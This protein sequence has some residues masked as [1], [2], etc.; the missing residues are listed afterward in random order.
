MKS[1]MERELKFEGD[2][3]VSID[4]LGGDAI[5]PRTFTSTY[6]DTADTLLLRLGLQLRRRL[7]HGKN[8]WQ[9]KLPREDGR[10]ELEAEGGPAGP[11]PELAGVLRASLDGRELR[12]VA[13]LRTQ[14]SGRRVDGVEVTLDAVEVLD[15]QRVASRF[16]EIEAEL[17]ADEP[18]R[19]EA[20][21]RRLR[22]GGARPTDGRSKV[23]RVL[24][25]S[26][27]EQPGRHDPA[28]AQLRAALR[29]QHEELLRHD[30]GVR[31]DEEPED[32]HAL[33]VAVRRLRAVLRA[34]RPML[35]PDWV[36]GLRAE[37]EWLGDHLAPVRD[38]DVLRA[39]LEGELPTLPPSDSESGRQL[40]A[41]LRDDYERAREALLGALDSDRYLQLL[42]ALDAAA[43]APRVRDADIRVEELARKEFRRLRKRRRR[44]G[45]DP[46]AAEL[47]KLRIRGKRARYAAELAASTRGGAAKRFIER[48]EAFQ[49]VLGEHQDAIVAEKAVRGLAARARSTGA[50]L[51]A[52]RIVE[53]Q[54]ARRREARDAFPKAWKRLRRAGNRAWRR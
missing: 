15:G 51:A 30:P 10:V 44:L 39:Y 6:Y 54:Q 12:P 1:T 3:G 29:T 34:A 18:R 13:K 45:P 47:H 36:D 23:R 28:L 53:R 9:L 8:V 32:V 52:G 33:R 11:P 19:L 2:G 37:L 43:A 16:T 46:S 21:E 17:V 35:D 40:L 38:L 22:K 20:L 48:A 4:D 25:P 31:V 14:R 50:S 26:E 5:E 42:D 41:P 7:E 27:P 24:E 49:D